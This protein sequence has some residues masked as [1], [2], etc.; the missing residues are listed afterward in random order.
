MTTPSISASTV[1][2]SARSSRRSSRAPLGSRSTR[3]TWSA[4][5]ARSRTS[6]SPAARRRNAR[7]IAGT[8]RRR[9]RWPRPTL[10]LLKRVRQRITRW[11]VAYD[12]RH[13]S[14]EVV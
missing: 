3:S 11:S 12:M 1:R 13:R 14:L 10:D 8:T 6:S 4:T 2:T 5:G 9:A 7:T